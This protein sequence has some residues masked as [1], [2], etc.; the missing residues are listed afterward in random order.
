MTPTRRRPDETGSALLIAMVL[1]V[2]FSVFV[3]EILSFADVA[4]KASTANEAQAKMNYG[5]DG[6]VEAAINRFRTGAACDDY[7][8]PTGP[9]GNSIGPVAMVVHCDNELIP[10]GG[11]ATRPANALLALGTDPSEGVFVTGPGA[12]RVRGDVVSN[13]RVGATVGGSMVVEGQVYAEGTCTPTGAIQTVPIA[14][15]LHCDGNGVDPLRGRDPDFTPATSSPPIRRT[16]PSCPAAP[17]WLVTLDPGYYDDAAALSGLTTGGTC[18]GKVVWLRPGVYYFDFSFRGAASTA[19]TI[20]DPV[21]NVIG[22]TPK[23]WD[24]ATGA[25]APRPALS[26]PGGCQVPGD[27]GPVDGVQVILGGESRLDV[28]EG[29]KV[30]LCA[31][32]SSS[33][34]SIAVYGLQADRPTHTPTPTVV[35]SVTGFTHP[36]NALTI[37]EL[38]VAPDKNTATAELASPALPS[39]SITVGAFRPRIPEGSVIDSA[40]LRVAHQDKDNAGVIAVAASFPGETCGTQSLPAHP[41]AVTVDVVDLKACGL[42]RSSRFA[43]LAVTYTASLGAGGAPGADELDGIALDVAYRSPVTRKPTSAAGT[44]FANPSNGFDIGERPEAVAAA[45]LSAGTPTAN[46]ALT[47]FGDPPIPTGSL[48][49][50]AVLRV[51]HRDDGDIGSVRVAPSFPGS[52]CGTRT[53]TTHPGS[54]VEDEVDLRACGLNTAAALEGLSATY[55]ALLAGGGTSATVTLDGIALDLVYRPP[56]TRPAVTSSATVFTNDP[57]ARVIDGTTADAALIPAA[58]T[59]SVIL[60]GYDQPAVPAGS[61]IDSAFLRVVHREDAGVG[62]VTVTASFPASACTNRPLP[63]HA[64]LVEDK[65]DLKNTCGLTSA[66]Q[67]TGLS[68]T[69]SVALAGAAL[70]GADSLDGIVLDLVYRP[71]ATHKPVST[72][73]VGGFTSTDAARVINGAT[74]DATLNATTTE[75]AIDLRQFDQPALPAGA[76]L[77]TAVLRVA[78]SDSGDI[79]ALSMTA[80]FDASVCGPQVLPRHPAIATQTVN[81]TTTCGLTDPTQ[82]AGLSATFSVS[83]AAG[84]SAATARLDGIELDVAYHVSSTRQGVT[85]SGSGFTNPGNARVIDGA[86]ADAVL[87]TGST[88]ATLQVAGHDQPPLP[89][90]AVID[91]AVL[92][93]THRDDAGVGQSAVLPTFPS[94]TCTTPYALALRPNVLGTDIV[95]LKAGCGLNDPS[96]LTGLTIT[97]SASLEA[98]G[99]TAIDRLDGIELDVSYH[100]AVTHFP[101]AAGAPAVFTTPANATTVDGVTADATVGGAGGSSAALRLAGFGEPAL[102]PGSVIDSLMLRVAHRDEPGVGQ[103]TVSVRFAGSTCAIRSLILRPPAIGEDLI[104]LKACGLTDATLLAGLSVTYSAFAGIDGTPAVDHLDGAV[105]AVVFRPPVFEPLKC[106]A[107]TPG[108]AHVRTLPTGAP[109]PAGQTQLVVQGTIYTPSAAVDINLDRVRSQVVTRGVVARTIRLRLNPDTGYQRPTAGVPPEAVVFTAYPAGT[110]TVAGGDFAD[111][112][113]AK[114][115]GDSSVAHA[116]AP[117]PATLTL[118][119]FVNLQRL[120][121][122]GPVLVVAH[123]DGAD[124]ASLVLELTVGADPPLVFSSDDPDGC[125]LC[126]HHDSGTVED[127]LPLPTLT[128]A[129]PVSIVFKVTFNALPGSGEDLDGVLIAP[130]ADSDALLRARVSFDGQLPPRVEGWSVLR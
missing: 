24:P 12:L 118:G 7:P 100:A 116:S 79:G 108:C 64:T 81:L 86:T 29:A 14:D 76:V 4:L 36:G 82:L 98:G 68:V 40:T 103:V 112:D 70:T 105:V 20:T 123:R 57:N 125:T 13:S 101:A 44:G 87:S 75:A 94:N 109:D 23:G 88:S 71:P 33:D 53:L 126:V 41:A 111:G 117:A 97:Y 37:G 63:T 52:T 25:A 62:A 35:S 83:L 54:I 99:T 55:S 30:E 61:V 43:E 9:G 2:I 91:S 113:Y 6:A 15:E 16:V 67:M 89:T 17:A 51:A 115:V 104:D 26:A 110:P 3:A 92:R 96:R 18:A 90:G 66:S 107:A 50:S 95:D 73:P 77:D 122:A 32:P 65:L 74:A 19:W 72:G 27:P 102:P 106:P 49:D 38:A 59:A 93:V 11:S 121:G 69:Y 60:G 120:S 78:Y 45:T 128:A 114:V 22:G 10:A 42:D 56:V 58:P 124:V 127:R 31:E 47:G 8:A 39:A 46:I 129:L 80:P 34:Q 119:G 48:I 5:A 28:R 21:V 84:G 130:T 85:T 1:T